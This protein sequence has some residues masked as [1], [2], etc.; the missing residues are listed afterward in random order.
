MVNNYLPRG[1]LFGLKGITAE[2]VERVGGG[3][4]CAS[5]TGRDR[6]QAYTEFASTNHMDRWI[7]LR[8][9]AELE[10]ALDDPLIARHLARLHGYE[11]IKVPDIKMPSDWAKAVGSMSKESG[12]ALGA[13]LTAF[14]NDGK[15]GI[16]EIQKL[17]I[18]GELDEA[19]ITLLQ[20]RSMIEQVKEAHEDG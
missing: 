8:E 2:T 3:T 20:I 12:E 14:A 4:R 15:I 13:V 1:D 6:R 7:N 10:A 5:I 19:I 11:L 9:V 16:D 17:H 18:D